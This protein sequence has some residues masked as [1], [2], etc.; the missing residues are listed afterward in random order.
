[1]KGDF[2]K[3]ETPDLSMISFHS[4]TAAIEVAKQSTQTNDKPTDVNEVVRTTW[5]GTTQSTQIND[6]PEEN[7]AVSSQK[8]TY[9]SFGV[10]ILLLV[11]CF[12]LC[13]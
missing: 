2:H 11:L 8:I 13:F 9:I 7:N 12:V 6:K 1:M 10:T 4:R 5:G 3:F